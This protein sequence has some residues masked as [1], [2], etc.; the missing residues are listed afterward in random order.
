MRFSLF[1]VQTIIVF[2]I[3]MFVV[4]LI[5]R[6]DS[7]QFVHH[8]LGNKCIDLIWKN[9]IKQKERRKTQQLKT[10]PIQCTIMQTINISSAEVEKSRALA[11]LSKIM[12]MVSVNEFSLAVA[13]CINNDDDIFCKAK[14]KILQ[15]IL[16]FASESRG[17]SLTL[18]VPS[19][20]K[21]T[22]TAQNNQVYMWHKRC[23]H[24]N[25]G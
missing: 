1:L 14:T 2:I 22:S 15:G 8:S 7:F 23:M 19:S 6:R 21:N 4:S 25:L 5:R 17:K 16:G 24:L 18:H 20:Q 13:F 11:K 9:A 10:L 12:Q 3:F